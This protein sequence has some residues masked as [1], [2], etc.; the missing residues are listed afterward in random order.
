MR[1]PETLQPKTLEVFKYMDRGLSINEAYKLVKPEKELSRQGAYE[2]K[3]KHEQY[4]LLNPKRVKK[5]ALAIDKTLNGRAIGDAA[6]PKH[7]DVL[8]AARQVLD[9]AEP[10]VT[11]NQ[12]FNVNADISPVNLDSYRTR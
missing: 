3:K 10:I 1:L 12:N 2:L 6:P 11:V 4:S 7:S 8:N 9:R 5:A